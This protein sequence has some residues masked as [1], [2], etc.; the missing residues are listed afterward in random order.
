MEV[1]KD[2]RLR[3]VVNRSF[4]NLAIEYYWGG[5]LHEQEKGF[6]VLLNPEKRKPLKNGHND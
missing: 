5:D 2:I 3:R 1:P 4:Q 6:F